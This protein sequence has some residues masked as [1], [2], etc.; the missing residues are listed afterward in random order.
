[1]PVAGIDVSK[2]QGEIEW[3]KAKNAGAQFAIIRAG[4]IDNPSG[5]PYEDF[6]F[7]RN[8]GLAPGFMPVGFYWYFRPNHNP[9]TQA[10]YFISL[11][12]GKQWKIYPA[13]DVEENG[14][15]NGNNVASAVWVFLNRV[16]QQLRVRCLIYSSPGF[17]NSYVARST[18]AREYPLWVAHWNVATPA[19]PRDWSE[20]GET[21]K[22]WQTH[23]GNDGP[24]YGMQ[25]KGLDHNVYNGNYDQFV[26]EFNLGGPPPPPDTMPFDDFVIEKLYPLMVERWGYDGPRPVKPDEGAQR[27]KQTGRTS[28][29]TEE[30]S[31]RVRKTPPKK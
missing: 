25:S 21:Y 16:Y 30:T 22:F 14:G 5:T 3:Q 29:Q 10:E 27:S 19:L 28:K 12:E 6:Q 9:L 15:L 1:M 26:R 23:V 17:W 4:S 2:W 13:L 20:T 7:Q 11:L 31:K 18:W 8:A 24:D